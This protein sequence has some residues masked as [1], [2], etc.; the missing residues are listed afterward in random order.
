[1]TWQEFLDSKRTLVAALILLC[2]GIYVFIFI[3]N[4]KIH[5]VPVYACYYS[6]ST[7]YTLANQYAGLFDERLRQ[8]PSTGEWLAPENDFRCVKVVGDSFDCPELRHT[9][10][11]EVGRLFLTDKNVADINRRVVLRYENS[12]Y[13]KNLNLTFV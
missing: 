6:E 2:I 1:M 7:E 3:V 11:A 8:D 9:S 10:K 12:S 13:T 4:A 5:S